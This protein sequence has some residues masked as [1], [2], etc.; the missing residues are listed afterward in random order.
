MQM[1]PY[2]LNEAFLAQA[3]NLICLTCHANAVGA[4]HYSLLFSH[5]WISVWTDRPTDK[6]STITLRHMRR[7]LTTLVVILA[8]A[9]S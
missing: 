6:P 4:Y 5:R 9:Y 7:G 3:H 2:L 1:M 8:A